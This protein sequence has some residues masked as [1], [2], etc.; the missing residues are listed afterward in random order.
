[1]LGTASVTTDGKWELTLDN[2]D[3]A[4]IGYG[5]GKQITATQTDAAGNEATVTSVSFSSEVLSAIS[6]LG[7]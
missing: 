7:S 1:M 6:G 3:V 4:H 2:A 5:G